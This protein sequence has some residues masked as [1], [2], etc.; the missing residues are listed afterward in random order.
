MSFRELAAI[1]G[2]APPTSYHSLVAELGKDI[3]RYR[4]FVLFHG[5]YVCPEYLIAYHRCINGA[6]V[7]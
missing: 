1:P 5:D 2:V 3:V 7:R 6:V 4:E